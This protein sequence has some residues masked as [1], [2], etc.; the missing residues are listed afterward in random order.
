MAALQ[1]DTPAPVVIR[2]R[3]IVVDGLGPVELGTAFI[4]L[5]LAEGTGVRSLEPLPE[6]LL[7]HLTDRKGASYILFKEIA[8]IEDPFSC[9]AQTAAGRISRKGSGFSAVIL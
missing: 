8:A 6:G 4:P 9:L 1:L 7:R 3:L 5:K 2:R